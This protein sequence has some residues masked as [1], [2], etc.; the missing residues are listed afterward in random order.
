MEVFSTLC[1]EDGTLVNL[2]VTTLLHY[3]IWLH[4]ISIYHL[5][6]GSS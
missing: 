4:S 6:H 2:M 3:Q 1:T 5:Y